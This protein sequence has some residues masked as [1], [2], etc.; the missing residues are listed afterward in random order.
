MNKQQ[1]LRTLRQELSKL[2]MEEIV[3][4]T[5]Y[6]EEC[7]ADATEGL[8]EEARLAEEE[9]LASEFGNPKRI[10]AEIKA[11]YAARLL[12]GDE[13]SGGAKAGAG[14]KLSAVWWIIIGICSAP[15]AIPI[16]CCAFLIMISIYAA[17]VSCIISGMASIIIGC[18]GLASSASAGVMTIGIGLIVLSLSTAAAVGAFI[19]TKAIIKAFARKIRQANNRR[20]AARELVDD[21][22]EWVSTVNGA[23]YSDGEGEWAEALSSET[24]IVERGDE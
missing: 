11:D 16:V 7:F 21:E 3:E 17:I 18:I 14:A 20:K 15:V 9:R 5:E 22:S 19:G 4:A 24:A 23:T 2:P 1:F 13:A 10:A 6:F 12:E 8:D